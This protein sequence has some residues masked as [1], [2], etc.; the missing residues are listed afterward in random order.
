MHV[1]RSALENNYAELSDAFSG[2]NDSRIKLNRD[3]EF[4]HG[5]DQVQCSIHLWTHNHELFTTVI[6]L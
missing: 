3:F 2:V 1:K 4:K 6:L 5:K